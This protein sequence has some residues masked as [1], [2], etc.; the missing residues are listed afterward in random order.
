M[1]RMRRASIFGLCDILEVKGLLFNTLHIS[2]EKQMTMFLHGCYNVR[3]RVIRVNFLRSGETVSR[4][5]DHVLHAIG[6]LRGELILPP[7][8][9][10][11]PI[12]AQDSSH[13]L[14]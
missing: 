6:E 4:Y 14:R 8:T 2:V 13:I 7:N 9:A 3:N 5:F 12:V 11:S 1:L 10:T